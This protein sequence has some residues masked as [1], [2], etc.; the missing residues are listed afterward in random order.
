L[1]LPDAFGVTQRLPRHFCHA[2]LKPFFA[3]KTTVSFSVTHIMKTRKH[4]IPD[5]LPVTS[6][7]SP[8][9]SSP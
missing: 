7:S 9:D 3:L 1:T 4:I 6:P 2:F 5:R 8:C